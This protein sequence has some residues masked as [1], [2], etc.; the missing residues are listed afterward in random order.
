MLSWAEG[1]GPQTMSWG[2]ELEDLQQKPGYQEL[3]SSSPGSRL[4]WFA[5]QFLVVGCSSTGTINLYL[6]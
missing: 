6:S 1:R 4:R 2:M 3:I 5:Q